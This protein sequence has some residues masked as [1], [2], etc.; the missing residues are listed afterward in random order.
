MTAIA[1]VLAGTAGALLA[2]SLWE[3]AGVAVRWFRTR[4]RTIAR[5]LPPALRSLIEPLR[6]VEEEGTL[7]SARDRVRLR[8]AAG[9]TAF[10]VALWLL[11][12]RAALVL[13]ALA[14]WLTSRF[15]DW[16]RVRYGGRLDAGASGAALALADALAG[17]RSLRGAIEVAARRLEGPIGVE[18]ERVARELELGGETEPTLERLRRRAQSRRIDLIV[19]ALRLQRRAGG[20]LV[21]LLRRVAAAIDDHDRVE[22]EARTASAQARFTALTVALMPVCGLLLGELASPGLVSRMAGNVIGV[23]LCG[24]ALLLQAAGL[25]LIRR[26]G[27]VEP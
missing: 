19:A 3:A 17:G 15:L 16:R 18:L 25:I 12:L 8:L 2:P 27:R 1:T 9:T 10:T 11:G 6:R 5:Y 21:A 26:L 20:N 23:W 7:P 4:A 14:A 22:D 24:A 13:A